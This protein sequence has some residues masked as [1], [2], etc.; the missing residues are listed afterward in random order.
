MYLLSN[1]VCIKL[2]MFCF[3]TNPKCHKIDTFSNIGKSRTALVKEKTRLS[4][5]L[6]LKTCKININ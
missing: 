1:T 2:N 4:G 3:K 5:Y 6:V